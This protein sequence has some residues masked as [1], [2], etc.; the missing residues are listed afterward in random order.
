MSIAF[1][2]AEGPWAETW[3]SG[4]ERWGPN[5]MSAKVLGWSNANTL[6]YCTSLGPVVSPGSREVYRIC[7]RRPLLPYLQPL[8][9]KYSLKELLCLT[10]SN[11][12]YWVMVELAPSPKPL[13]Q[14]IFTSFEHYEEHLPAGV[15]LDEIWVSP[16]KANR[17][18]SEPSR[19]AL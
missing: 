12:K 3:A 19:Y 8:T 14:E 15:R 16:G 6:F 17:A 13:H 11:C 9:P 5:L 10:Q 4:A 7:P 2:E 1:W 18:E